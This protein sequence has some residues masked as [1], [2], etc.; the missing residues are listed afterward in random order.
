[1]FHTC[2]AE[3]NYSASSCGFGLGKANFWV[4]PKKFTDLFRKAGKKTLHRRD[5]KRSGIVPHTP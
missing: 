3:S 2:F 5:K 1:M 4:S